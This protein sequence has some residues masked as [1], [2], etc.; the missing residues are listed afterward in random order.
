M[1][2]RNCLVCKSDHQT[3]Y[4]HLHINKGQ[5][6]VRVYCCKCAK[7]FTAQQYADAANIPIE[8]IFDELSNDDFQ[9]KPRNI[10]SISL[11][12]SFIS[13]LDPRA[14][15]G[16]EYLKKRGI[17]IYPDLMYDLFRR[18]IAQI[19]YRGD[20]IVGSQVRII[21]PK[22]GP[23]VMSLK[24]TQRSLALWGWN[25]NDYLLQGVKVVFLTEGVFDALSIRLSFKN[26]STIRV[27]STLGCG[28]S[29]E[30]IELLQQI[31]E[32][33]IKLI[34]AF[35]GDE[36]GVRGRNFLIKNKAIDG[37]IDHPIL[38]EKD[39]N[40]LLIESRDIQTILR[41]GYHN[42][43]MDA[44]STKKTNFKPTKIFTE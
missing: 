7:I 19:L 9:D 17:T 2:H 36:A 27:I 13:I 37:Y 1:P 43:T 30:Q 31:R 21:D 41:E 32:K 14:K 18:G 12:S 6:V 15:E 44:K 3:L 34:C 16:R 39:W 29:K 11:P 5:K 35:D 20:I 33:G 38:L 26:N 23:K 42:A 10:N 4:W 22:D 25:G 24:G 8:S 40:K 28:T